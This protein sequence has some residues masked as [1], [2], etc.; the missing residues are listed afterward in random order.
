M[1]KSDYF[2]LIEVS[3]GVYAAIS[4]DGS[5]AMSNSGII[6]TGDDVIIFDTF[7]SIDAAEELKQVAESLTGK[8]VGY[9]INSHYHFDHVGGNQVFGQ[10]TKI[11]STKATYDIFKGINTDMVKQYKSIGPEI[12]TD[13]NSQLSREKESNN[14]KQ[15]K[16]QLAYMT[17]LTREDLEVTLPNLLFKGMLSI[18]GTEN[19]IELIAFENGHTRSDTVLY[20]PD[21][22]IMFT[23]DLVFIGRHPWLGNGNPAY[24]METLDKL[25]QMSI[26]TLIPGHGSLGCRDDII[27]LEEYITTITGIAEKVKNGCMNL[28]D[29]HQNLLES[30][31]NSWTGDKLIPNIEFL[32][33]NL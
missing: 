25:K 30:P 9:V 31:Y 14:I 22:D 2:E 33:Q 6:D 24:L 27:M 26:G 16:N 11:I 1:Y 32:A 8:R 4:Y 3:L 15:L 5:Y 19:S 18:H 10:D 7:L 21:K 29:V 13:I 12:I 28:Q 17:S 23:G 20:I